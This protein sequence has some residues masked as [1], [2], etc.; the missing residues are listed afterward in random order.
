MSKSVIAFASLVVIQVSIGLIYKLAASEA[1]GYSFSKASAL[2]MSEGFKLVLSIFLY[3]E[4]KTSQT[5]DFIPFQKDGQKP[6][7]DI[8]SM[9]N[10][11]PGFV[12]NGMI[13]LAFLY[14]VNNHIF[15]YLVTLAD[16]GTINLV[17]SA[18]TFLSA[19]ILWMF[20]GR[21]PSKLQWFAIC[22]QTLGLVTSQVSDSLNYT[23]I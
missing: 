9:A 12:R 2:T 11:V 8:R 21:I 17:K 16:P 1:G 19:G 13:I 22:F 15:F 3:H 4:S 18:S 6:I 14:L 7:I 23:S 5:R 20:A 10:E